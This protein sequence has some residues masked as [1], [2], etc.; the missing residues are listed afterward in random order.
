MTALIE[1][2]RA[3][4]GVLPLVWLHRSRLERSCAALNLPA[5][6]FWDEAERRAA[7]IGDGVVRVV[8]NGVAEWSTR[9]AGTD[10]VVLRTSA[11][12]H[13]PYP[14]KTTAREV[15]TRAARAV[16]TE[17]PLLLTAEG[18]VAETPRF[19]LS[20]FDGGDLCA[21]A[22][23]LGILRSVA[24]AR[25][26]LLTEVHWCQTALG[27]VRGRPLAVV[28]AARGL[29]PV[30]SLDGVSVDPD[31]RWADLAERFWPA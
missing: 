23:A 22:P 7:E 5:P 9:A 1:T 8:W 21:V 2:M 30:A 26:E 18:L 28:N 12:P 10:P 17:E 6:G 25:L 27:L 24:I 15:F 14:H 19:A 16:G 31:A 13:A 29:Q 4:G 11:V 20:W 3:R